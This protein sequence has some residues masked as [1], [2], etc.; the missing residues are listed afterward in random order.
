MVIIL[1]TIGCYSIVGYFIANHWWL[2]M[3][4]LL[5]AIVDILLVNISGYFKYIMTIGGYYIICYCWIF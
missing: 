5:M 1:L 2:L 4:I 3:V